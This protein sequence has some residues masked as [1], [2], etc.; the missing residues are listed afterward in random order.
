M[1]VHYL[2]KAGEVVTALSVLDVRGGDMLHQKLLLGEFPSAIPPLA[3]QYTS[4]L[5]QS[6]LG[7]WVGLKRARQRVYKVMCCI[8]IYLLGDILKF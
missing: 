2:P 5:F 7:Y 1:Y 4:S 6:I 8:Y 3:G